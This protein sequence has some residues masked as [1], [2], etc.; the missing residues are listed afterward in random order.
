MA[1]AETNIPNIV[2]YL[3]GPHLVFFHKKD[4]NTVLFAYYKPQDASLLLT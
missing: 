3:N 4:K 1:R 2:N